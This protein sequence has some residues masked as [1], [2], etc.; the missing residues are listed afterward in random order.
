MSLTWIE[1]L[2]ELRQRGMLAGK[3]PQKG[4]AEYGALM[5]EA[6]NLGWAP[7]GKPA[8]VLLPCPNETDYVRGPTNRCKLTSRA[9]NTRR[10]AR[11]GV[12]RQLPAGGLAPCPNDI[13]YM[14]GPTNRCKLTRSAT[15]ARKSAKAKATRLARAGFRESVRD[16]ARNVARAT[17]TTMPEATAVVQEALTNAELDDMLGLGVD[18]EKVVEIVAINAI[19][20]GSSVDDEMDALMAQLEGPDEGQGLGRRRSSKPAFRSLGRG[21]SR[22][23]LR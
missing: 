8:K 18:E 19:N 12:K 9:A 5:A 17:R 7:S 22:L 16:I 20:T 10:R 23:S 15:L 6:R 13:E 11:A 21:F 14:R 2:H 1:A 3:L 4:S